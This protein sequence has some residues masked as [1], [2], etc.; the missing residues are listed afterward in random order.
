[1]RSMQECSTVGNDIN[2]GTRLPSS[3]L[4]FLDSGGGVIDKYC[5]ERRVSSG[6]K[7]SK[8]LSG[9]NITQFFLLGAVHT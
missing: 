8:Q 7:P 9:N 5:A 4:H 6:T 1:M 2:S 3:Y